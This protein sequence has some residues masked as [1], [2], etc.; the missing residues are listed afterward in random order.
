MLNR[1]QPPA[2]R[3]ISGLNRPEITCLRLPNQIPMCLINMGEQEVSR[4]DLLFSAGRYE[5][6]MPLCATMTN[7]ML[8]EGAGGLSSAEIAAKLDYYGA[9]LQTTV[10]AHHSYITLYSLNKYADET[11][12]VLEKIVKCPEFP[13][14]AFSTEIDRNIQRYL[15]EQEKVQTLAANRF[16]QVMFGENHPFGYNV[17][18][19]DF[20]HLT[21]DNLKQFHRR[22]YNREHCRILVTGHITDDL[23]KRI[24]DAFG[25]DFDGNDDNSSISN[26]QLSPGKPGEYFIEKDDALQSAIRIGLPLVPREHPDYNG[27]RVLNTLLGGYFG[28]RL[29]SNIREEKGYTYGIGSSVTTFPE[30]TF[31]TIATQTGI[32]FTRPLINEVFNETDRLINEQVTPVELNMVTSYLSGQLSRYFDGAFATAD[33]YLSLL[34]NKLPFDYF[35]RQFDEYNRITPAKLQELSQKYLEREKFYTVVAGKLK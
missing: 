5:Q 6:E 10:G 29:M 8:K 20:E 27:L 16:D 25:Y 11:L 18:R 33:S 13:L 34:A 1:Q 2:I 35:N 4:I 17:K 12:P 23:I 21:T 15:I 28:S 32:E 31:L 9:W 19:S 14:S 22:W 3:P 26:H 7:N 24:T 30:T